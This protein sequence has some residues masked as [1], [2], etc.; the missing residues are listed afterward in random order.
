MAWVCRLLQPYLS[1]VANVFEFIRSLC[2][3]VE[4]EARGRFPQCPSR[5]P[6]RRACRRGRPPRPQLERFNTCMMKMRT[7]PSALDYWEGK[8]LYRRRKV[9]TVSQVSTGPQ[10]FNHFP[11]TISFP[12]SAAVPHQQ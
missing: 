4:A 7:Q 12:F 10:L 9:N 2:G 3:C 5:L 6:N 11:I 1:S 8:L